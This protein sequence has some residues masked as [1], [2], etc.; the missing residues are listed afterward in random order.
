MTAAKRAP[1]KAV[2]DKYVRDPFFYKLGETEIE[3]PSL[4]YLKPGLVRRLR[5]LNGTDQMYTLL[6][7]VLDKDALDLID[8]MDPDEFD[9][10]R[11]AWHKHSGIEP[12]ES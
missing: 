11:E 6:E 10:M 2:K 3:L 9:A 1:V 5:R 12:G 8:E 7:E 4:S